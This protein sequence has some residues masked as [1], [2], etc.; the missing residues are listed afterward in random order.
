MSLRKEAKGRGC[1]VRIP[2]VCNFNSE[3]VVLAHIRLAGVSGMG[4]KS[5]DLLGAWACSACHD[6]IDGRT[7]KSGL[8][9]D[10]LRLAHYDGMART[11]VQLEKEGLV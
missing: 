2:N 3:T 10:E 7:H 1:T 11:I 4:M 6:E 9:R 5:P 8:S